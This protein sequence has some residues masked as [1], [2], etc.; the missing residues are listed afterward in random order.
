MQA[1]VSRAKGGPVRLYLLGAHMF[2]RPEID[3]ALR[4]TLPRGARANRR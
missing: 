1:E 2:E 3:Q 4:P